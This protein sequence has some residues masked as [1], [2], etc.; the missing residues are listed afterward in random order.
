MVEVTARYDGNLYCT[1][2][3]TDSGATLRTSAPKDNQGEGNGFSPTD[4]VGTA[5]GTCMLTIMGLYARRQGFSIDGATVRVLKEMSATP[6]R[7]IAKL[8]VEFTVP[9][10]VPAEFRQRFEEAALSCPVHKSMHPDIQMPV[11]F[12]YV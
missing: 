12:R 8:T 10:T 5:M 11:T 3:H 2:N 6:P 9:A 1:A 4:L 7:R